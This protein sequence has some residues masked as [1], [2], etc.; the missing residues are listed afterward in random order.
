MPYTHSF[1]KLFYT[2]SLSY[3]FSKKCTNNTFSKNVQTT[4]QLCPSKKKTTQ[5]C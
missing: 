5:L 1:K 2:I 3:N 4:P